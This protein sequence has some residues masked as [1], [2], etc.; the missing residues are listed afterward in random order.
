MNEPIGTPVP[1]TPKKNNTVMIIV[2]VA[3]VLCCCCVGIIGGYY[4][5]TYLWNNG[6]AILGTGLVS[7]LL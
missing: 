2:I 6:D 1:A 3:V 4:G 7:N 5:I